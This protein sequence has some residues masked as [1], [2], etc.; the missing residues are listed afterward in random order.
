MAFTEQFVLDVTGIDDAQ[1]DALVDHLGEHR[2]YHFVRWLQV[3]E[4][5]RRAMLVLRHHSRR[6][7]AR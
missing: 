5:R 2:A 6:Q 3:A 1:V 7:F 4:A